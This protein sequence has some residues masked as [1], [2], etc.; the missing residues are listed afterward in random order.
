M[1]P[2][3][4]SLPFNQRGIYC[5]MW[6]QTQEHGD[7]GLTFKKLYMKNKRLQAGRSI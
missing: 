4:N 3:S 2:K 5:E 7:G 1:K 6:H